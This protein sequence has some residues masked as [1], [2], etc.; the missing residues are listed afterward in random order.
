M[1]ERCSACSEGRGE[2]SE[3]V[4]RGGETDVVVDK[5]KNSPGGEEMEEEMGRRKGRG[6]EGRRNMEERNNKK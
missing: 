5:L 2:E 1:G 3:R 4:G 6:R